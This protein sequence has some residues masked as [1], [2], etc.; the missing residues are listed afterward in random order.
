MRACRACSSSRPACPK[1]SA[2]PTA[3][4]WHASSPGFTLPDAPSGTGEADVLRT[5][6]SEWL[7]YDWDGEAYWNLDPG[8]WYRC[9][10]FMLD[11]ERRP[12]AGKLVLEIGIGI[13]GVANH[14]ASDHDA[15]VIGMDLGYAVDAAYRHFGKNPR[16]HLV[17]ASAFHPPFAGAT[18]DMVYSFGVLHHTA[19][20][21]GAFQQ[22]ARLP[23]AGGRLNVWVYSPGNETRSL[24]RRTIMGM[25]RLI[26]PVLWRLPEQVQAVAL[27]PIVPLYIGYQGLRRLRRGATQVTYGWREAM[28][29]ARD[30]FTPRYIHRHSDEEVAGW[31]RAAGFTDIQCASERDR[32]EWVPLAFTAN[33]GVDGVRQAT[34]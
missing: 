13:G 8:T 19:D 6:S 27:A 10:D 23:R 17:Q 34:A 14:N 24:I 31:F 22:V 33:T 12:L 9:M 28:H 3:S 18:F 32:P 30:R 5:F 2:G 1:R 15:E 21:R 7:N 4:G 26:R 16:L 29:A 11:V 25:E 20:T